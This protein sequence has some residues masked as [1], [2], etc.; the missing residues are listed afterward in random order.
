MSGRRTEGPRKGEREEGSLL[1]SVPAFVFHTGDAF[2][3]KRQPFEAL[4]DLVRFWDEG[5][6][7]EGRRGTSNLIR[8]SQWADDSNHVLTRSRVMERRSDKWLVPPS[9]VGFPLPPPP[10]SRMSHAMP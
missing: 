2:L 8:P 7:H 1:D 9:W 4:K 6:N 3:R 5:D 10:P